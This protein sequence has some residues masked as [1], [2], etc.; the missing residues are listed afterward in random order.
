M[1]VNKMQWKARKLITSNGKLF[2]KPKQFKFIF[3]VGDRLLGLHQ[4][5]HGNLF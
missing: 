5:K 1:T 4:L 2:L 3:S